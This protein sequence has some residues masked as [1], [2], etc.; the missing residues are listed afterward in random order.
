ME[1]LT[2]DQNLLRIFNLEILDAI[3][4]ER[5]SWI[6]Y[7]NYEDSTLTF[8]KDMVSHNLGRKTQRPQ[9]F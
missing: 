2:K 1:E 3:E 5:G 7:E 9:K 6:E 4:C 8:L